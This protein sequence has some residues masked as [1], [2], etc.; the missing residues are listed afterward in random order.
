MINDKTYY[1]RLIDN[2]LIEWEANQD[3]KPLLLRGARQVGKSSAVRQL[4]KQFTYFVEINFEAQPE[5]HEFFQRNLS[6]LQ[7]CE[8]ISI[9]TGI[10]IIQGQTLLFF[11]EIQS[12]IPALSSLRFFYEQMPGLHLIAAGSLLEFALGELSSFGVG[13]VRSAFMYPF[14]FDEFLMASNEEALVRLKQNASSDNPLPDIFHQKLIE[15]FKK[16]ILLGGMP[17]VISKYISHRQI[18]EIQYTL[19]DLLISYRADFVKYKKRIPQLTISEV[20][21]SVARQS[22]GKFV[23]KDAAVETTHKQIKVALEL[24]IMAGLVIPVTHTSANGIPLG[25]ESDTKKRKM[26]IMD[27]GLYQRVCGLN[28]SAIIAETSF[29]SINKGAIAEQFVGLELLKYTDPF[30]ERRLYYWHRESPGSNAEVDYI[31]QKQND[32]IPVEVKSSGKGSMQSIYQ[33]LKIKNR[34]RG[35][36]FSL[37]NFSELPQIVIIPLYAVSNVSKL[38]R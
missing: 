2:T 15:Y 14:S 1:K 23:F 38:I 22:G 25:A 33:F 30:S 9:Y 10:P 3:R 27:T 28:L 8:N 37:E 6:P 7:L 17:E 36:R 16:F 11:D 29:N 13:R 31:I 5:I 24:L 26:L 35:I 20:F 34:S 18:N 21:E 19:D 4:A 32:I 12:C